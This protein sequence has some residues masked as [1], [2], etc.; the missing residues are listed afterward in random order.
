[1]AFSSS[2]GTAPALACVAPRSSLCVA[3]RS[4]LCGAPRRARGE[5]GRPWPALRALLEAVVGKQTMQLETVAPEP[6]IGRP[7]KGDAGRPLSTTQQKVHQAILRAPIEVQELYR[8]GLVGQKVAA[9]LG[10]KDPARAPSREA[11]ANAGGPP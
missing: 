11:I 9:K 10:P 5:L 8:E 7:K 6:P 4:S 2:L 3:P 1:L